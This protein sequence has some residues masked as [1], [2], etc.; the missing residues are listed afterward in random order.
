M[1]KNITFDVTAWERFLNEVTRNTNAVT[2]LYRLQTKHLWS[3]NSKFDCFS[4]TFGCSN[5]NIL[6]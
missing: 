4:Y 3:P 2:F 1:Y 6:F 5:I